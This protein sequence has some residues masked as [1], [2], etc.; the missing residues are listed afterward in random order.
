M[1]KW[2]IAK[3]WNLE[4]KEL[5]FLITIVLLASFLRFYRLS[6]YM[7]FLGDEGRDAIVVKRML[8]EHHPPL[9]GPTMSVGNMYLGP[10]YYYMMAIP[11]GIFWLN[12]VS[13]AGMNA[14]IGVL[15]VFLIYYLARSWFGK[16]PGLV[17]AFA[18]A[19]SPVT[20]IYSR[21]SWNPNPA[22][23]FTLLGVLGLYKAHQT[24]NFLWLILTGVAL[25]FA[26]QMHY[27]SLILIPFLL[28]V[29]IFELF[30]KVTTKRFFFTGTLIAILTF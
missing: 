28:I 30:T 4:G 14:L 10:A 7:T 27:L 21:S 5:V 9:L 13:A 20:I 26:T 8:V 18:Y 29:W 15:T 6:E 17:V 2:F 23:F 25:A 16:Y 22:P 24:K 3:V 11:M 19:I 1:I 12:P